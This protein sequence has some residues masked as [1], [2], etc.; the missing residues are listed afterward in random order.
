MVTAIVAKR[1]NERQFINLY[2]DEGYVGNAWGFAKVRTHI[3]NGR[4]NYMICISSERDSSVHT[5]FHVDKIG[6]SLQS[7]E[8]KVTPESKA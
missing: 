1:M 8:G 2:C 6:R 7:W 5:Y 4:R 3:I